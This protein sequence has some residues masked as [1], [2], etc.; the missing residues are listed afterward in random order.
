MA[1]RTVNEML[2]DLDQMYLSFA[3]YEND[4]FKVQIDPDGQKPLFPYQCFTLVELGE[5][6]R[7]SR[8]ARSFINR[9]ASPDGQQ[10]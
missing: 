3:V 2:S 1:R 7:R 4:M 6:Y 10:A 9:S 8:M 5:Y